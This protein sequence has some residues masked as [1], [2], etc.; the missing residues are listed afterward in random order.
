MGLVPLRT[1]HAEYLPRYAGL[2]D[3][4]ELSETLYGDELPERVVGWRD[5]APAG[6][7]FMPK[8]H[9]GIVQAEEKGDAELKEAAAHLETLG[10]LGD[11]MGPMLAQFPPSFH[12]EGDHL[13]WLES[14]LA[15]PLPASCPG[16][17]VE[18]RHPSWWQPEVE[19]ALRRAGAALVWST[20]HK[21]F[22]PSWATGRFG[23]VR[24]VG[25][26]H[27]AGARRAVTKED[28][29]ED[30]LELRQRLAAPP[31]RW[32]ECYVIVTN[33]WEGNAI[34]SLPKVAA[35]LGQMELA[36]R[37]RRRPGETLLEQPAPSSG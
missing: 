35:G 29:T 9:K 30:L 31:A 26:H 10:A 28:R 33:T 8:L 5:Q 25:K 24:F 22:A 17:A 3:A 32:N 7:R 20:H 6:F 27:A 16:W 37:L 14:L 18:L 11:H 4:L 23:Y 34:D 2:F 15:L 21:A 1:L 13:A 19:K 36:Q 12:N